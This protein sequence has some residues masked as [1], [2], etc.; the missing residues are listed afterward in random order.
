MGINH[1]KNSFSSAAAA[2][3][4]EKKTLHIIMSISPEQI[5]SIHA[6]SQSLSHYN[7]VIKHIVYDNA[8]LAIQDFSR[9]PFFSSAVTSGGN[10]ELDL[11]D[12]GEQSSFHLLQYKGDL[13]TT[14]TLD[15]G[16]SDKINSGALGVAKTYAGT[17]TAQ[18]FVIVATR[19]VWHI[20]HVN[21]DHVTITSA[22]GCTIG[23]AY[24]DFTISV[25]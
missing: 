13:G 8:V 6:L 7:P 12:I 14:L 5:Q 18:F 16:A 1:Y 3:A 23:G 25:P 11:P 10:L 24:P 2:T 19:N 17:G 15:P 20:G 9:D 22:G 4:V 21:D